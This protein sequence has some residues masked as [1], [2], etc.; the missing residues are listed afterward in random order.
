VDY[1]LAAARVLLPQTPAHNAK[2]PGDATGR[3]ELAVTPQQQKDASTIL[4]KAGIRP[5]DRFAVLNPGGNNPAK[6]WP[7][8]RFG[9]IGAYLIR[10]YGLRI[11]VNGSPGEIEV[12]RA[13]AASVRTSLGSEADASA[14]L[15]GELSDLGITIG[16][17]KEIVRR[18]DLMVTNDTGP[19]HIAAAFATPTIAL[20]GPTDHRWTTLPDTSIWSDDRSASIA[21]SRELML[22][23]DPTLPQEEVA[24]DHPER[25]RIELINTSDVIAAIDAMRVATT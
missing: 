20:F 17:L 13:V 15:V 10:R 1:Y 18:A 8:E 9:E 4:E 5:G 22:L 7:A 24:D 14:P 6:R 11:L 12:V 16:S 3:L 25:C 21:A 19:R 23:A 2:G